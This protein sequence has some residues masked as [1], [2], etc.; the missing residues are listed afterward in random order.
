MK[1][2]DKLTD[3]R[4]IILTTRI[5][6]RDDFTC[7]D[8]GE[9]SPEPQVHHRY[10][11]AGL[12]P[13]EYDESVLRT[14]CPKCHGK[15]HGW[16]TDR[17]PLCFQPPICAYCGSQVTN[18]QGYGRNSRR[19]YICEGCIIRMEEQRET[20][21]RKTKVQHFNGIQTRL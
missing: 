2:K 14:L 5:L 21:E 8:C 4:W 1:Y 13:W 6:R 16:G 12:D 19:V 20:V 15:V 3:K 7:R 11:M 18:D 17:K 9:L 10:Y